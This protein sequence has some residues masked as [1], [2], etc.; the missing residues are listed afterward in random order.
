LVVGISGVTCGGKSTLTSHLL[1]A[2]PWAKV[3]YQD[4]YFH[5][6]DSPK[7]V[8]IDELRHANY[9]IISSYDMDK[10]WLDVNSALK[11]NGPSSPHNPH[12][13][14]REQFPD[15][16]VFAA[17]GLARKQLEQSQVLF[18]DGILLF[19]H[20]D[21]A[22][23][24]HRKYFL[25]LSKEQCFERRDARVY[26]PP[27]VPGYFDLCVWPEYLRYRHRVN[28]EVKGVRY[29][30]GSLPVADTLKMVLNELVES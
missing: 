5:P 13:M 8:W 10:M 30:D 16:E 23:L 19:D 6:E 11:D 3:V 14:P 28:N 25:T 15:Q 7:H 9:D 20:T 2:L 4:D 26:E 22:Q 12:S 1:K 17:V 18:L 29:F 27:D 24:C 21:L